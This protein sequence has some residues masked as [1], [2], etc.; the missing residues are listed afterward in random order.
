M[1]AES[2]RSIYTRTPTTDSDDNLFKPDEDTSS[3]VSGKAVRLPRLVLSNVE[4]RHAYLSPFSR[5]GRVGDGPVRNC[6]VEKDMKCIAHGVDHLSSMDTPQYADSSMHSMHDLDSLSSWHQP[7]GRFQGR[8]QFV[9]LFSSKVDLLTRPEE[10]IN[11]VH[12]Y[13][14]VPNWE[15]NM[16]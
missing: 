12:C 16:E 14:D 3:L 8:K 2:A 13:G 7:S 5:N 4:S 1:G 10:P 11:I 15:A 6:S 9:R